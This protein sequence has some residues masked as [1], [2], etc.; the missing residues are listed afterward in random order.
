[1]PLSLAHRSPRGCRKKL[2]NVGYM[3]LVADDQLAEER[4]ASPWGES[5]FF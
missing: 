3:Q 4:A 5:E 2:D 1:M